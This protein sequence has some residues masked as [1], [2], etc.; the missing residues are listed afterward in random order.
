MELTVEAIARRLHGRVIGDGSVLIHGVNMV[1]SAQ[2][3]ELSFAEN[4]RRLAQALDTAVS[5]LIVAADVQELGG[6]SGIGVSNPKLA[7]AAVLDLFHPAAACVAGSIH[8]SAVLG[9]HLQLGEQVQIRPHA[10]LGNRVS[11]GRG[12]TIESNVTI[13]D[14]V[15]IGDESL[16]GPNVV[17]YRQSRIGCRVKIHGGSVIGGDGFGYVFHEGRHVKVPQVGNVV[18]EDD[19]EIGCNVCVDRATL[20]ST[21][22]RQGAKIDNLVQIAHNNVIGRHVIITGMGGLSGSVTVGDYSVLGGRTTVTDHVAIGERVQVGLASVV[23]KSIASGQV[24]LGY[25]AR[26]AHRAKEQMAAVGRL[27]DMLTRLN[28]LLARLHSAEIAKP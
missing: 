28:G 14:D 2:A 8:P 18:I 16:I 11:I 10:V 23:T 1:E 20:G 9:D 6:K 25:P 13:G 12:T 4:P 21:V 27:P 24:V 22:I 17:V 3:G 7:F 5:A 19:V 15:V 26:P